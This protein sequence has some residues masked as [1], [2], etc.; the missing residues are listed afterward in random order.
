MV[1]IFFVRLRS[2]SDIKESLVVQGA[3]WTA[4]YNI[5][6]DMKTKDK[7]VTLTYKSSIIQNTGEVRTISSSYRAALLTIYSRTGSTSPSLSKLL[8]L[9]SG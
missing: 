1:C 9:H 6:V 2:I 4:G 7:P 8:P 5:R 3:T